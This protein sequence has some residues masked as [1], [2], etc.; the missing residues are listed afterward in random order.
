MGCD[1]FDMIVFAEHEK[2]GIANIHDEL[3]ELV[4]TNR[5]AYKKVEVDG[6]CVNWHFTGTLPEGEEFPQDYMDVRDY[7]VNKGFTMRLTNWG[8]PYFRKD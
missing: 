3:A 6:D 2:E 1:D 8:A 5:Y 7:L 4:R